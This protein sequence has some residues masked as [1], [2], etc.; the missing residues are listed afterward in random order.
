MVWA[1]ISDGHRT[2][3]HFNDGNLNAARYRDETLRPIAVPFVRLHDVTLQQDNARPH[4]ARVCAQLLEAEHVP[5]LPWP[6]YSP[7]MSPIEARLGCS[8][9]SVNGEADGDTAFEIDLEKLGTVHSCES[10]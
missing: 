6:A 8:G 7:D 9:S 4:V 1:G 3:L 2:R 5:V 10:G